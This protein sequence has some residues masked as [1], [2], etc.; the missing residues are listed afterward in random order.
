MH[1]LARSSLPWQ[2]MNSLLSRLPKESEGPTPEEEE[3]AAVE[4][5]IRMWPNSPGKVDAHMMEWRRK[6]N[7]RERKG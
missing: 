7:E 3:R 2:R 1:S 6:R 4:G 5:F